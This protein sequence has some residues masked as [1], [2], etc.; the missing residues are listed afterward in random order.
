MLT[1]ICCNKAEAERKIIATY[2]AEI[3]GFR[4]LFW[5]KKFLQNF[6]TA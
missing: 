1:V 4:A 2:I 3:L 5:V 6:V